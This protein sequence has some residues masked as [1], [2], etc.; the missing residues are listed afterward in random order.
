[1]NDNI[2]FKGLWQQQNN[3]AIPAAAGIFKKA[4]ALKTKTRNRY[5]FAV[6]ILAATIA[7]I[8]FI[9]FTSGLQM[10][11]SKIGTTLV[12]VAIVLAV[13]SSVQMLLVLPKNNLSMDNSSYLQQLLKLKRR[14]EFMQKTILSVY[15]ILLTAGLLLYMVEPSSKMSTGS[16]ILAYSLTIGWI[17]FAWFYLRPKRIKKQQREINDII[18][19]LENINNQMQGKGY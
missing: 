5:I 16:A 10:L 6:A 4:A 18:N 11:T 15:F 12:I 3:E 9:W 13:F 14:Q 8:L 17:A 7:F 1:M 2:D 19:K